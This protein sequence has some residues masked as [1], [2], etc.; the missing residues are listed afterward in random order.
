MR[1]FTCN[2]PNEQGESDYEYFEETGSYDLGNAKQV[3]LKVRFA[4][5]IDQQKPHAFLVAGDDNQK[6]EDHEEDG[7][8]H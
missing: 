7:R 1:H 3:E 4:L 5:F 8:A 2:K 6:W